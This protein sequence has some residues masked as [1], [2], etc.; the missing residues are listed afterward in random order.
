MSRL[1]SEN[2]QSIIELTLVTPL[3][4]IAL[5]IPFDF[6]IGMYTGHLTQIAVRDAVRIGATTYDPFDSAAANA[7]GDD[8]LNRLP[9]LLTSPTVTVRYNATG[10]D[11]LINV[12]VEASGQYNFFLYQLM[13][14]FG[15][16][17]S[18]SI[19]MARATR[20][21]YE[22]QP[23]TNGGSSS[24]TTMCTETFSVERP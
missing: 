22:F 17:V 7:V 16:S 18:N 14:M 21:R 24:T 8:T 13:R 15:F 19:P 12:A 6:G 23:D 20:M 2:G 4:L 10:T 9:T 5:Y 11:C 1:G 3:L